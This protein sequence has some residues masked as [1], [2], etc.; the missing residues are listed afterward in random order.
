MLDACPRSGYSL[1][2]LPADHACP[3]CGLRYDRDSE[4]YK[5]VNPKA[6]FGGMLGFIGGTGGMVNIT[7]SFGNA[8]T[9]W[10]VC[11]ILSLVIYFGALVWLVRYAY[12]LYRSGPL[13]AVLP[14]GLYVRLRR[15]RGECIPWTR[16]TRAVL[17][18]K[19]K[20][21][22]VIFSDGRPDLNIIGVFAS[23]VDS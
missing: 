7:H 1:N 6:L 4:V 16:V 20:G 22:S 10:R 17:N 3:E 11:I 18:Q 15:I 14:E 8:R 23:P 5:H 19:H 13:V 21:A 12:L 9:F 2:G